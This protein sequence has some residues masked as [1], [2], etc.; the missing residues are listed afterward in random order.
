MRFSSNSVS[1]VLG[2]ALVTLTVWWPAWASEIPVVKPPVE[3]E[4]AHYV[5][6]E[7]M[8][9]TVYQVQPTAVND[10][11]VTTYTLETDWGQVKAV[12]DYRLRA[13]IQEVKALRTLDEMSRAGVF[14]DALVEGALAP[15]ET[16][17]D[18][19]TEPVDTVSDAAEGMGQ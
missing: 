9:G 15:V 8:K 16:V 11:Y 19:V 18:L 12:S 3:L 7:L 13:R 14:G 1:R 17:V 2:V 6:G 4:A 5:P 10:G